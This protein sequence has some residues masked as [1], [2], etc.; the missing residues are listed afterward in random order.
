[1]KAPKIRNMEDFAA[2]SGLSRPTVSKYFHDPESVRP[3]TRQRIESAL[4]QYDFRPNIFAMNQNRKLTK[5][6]GIVVPNLVDPYFAEI[7][8]KLERRC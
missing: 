3:S 8:R 4:E 2:V 6:V 1:M 5:I 7:A